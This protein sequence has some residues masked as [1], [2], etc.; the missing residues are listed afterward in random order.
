[1]LLLRATVFRAKPYEFLVTLTPLLSG[2]SC[3]LFME[4]EEKELAI[5]V[6]VVGVLFGVA[7]Y[8]LL[9]E[10]ANLLLVI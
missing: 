2:F 1:M 3:K 6:F 4:R 5:G 7:S 8:F 9:Q 10:V